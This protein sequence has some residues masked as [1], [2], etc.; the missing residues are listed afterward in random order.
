MT[1]E[2]SAKT[3]KFE[4]EVSQVLSLV[5]NSL[6]SNKDVFLRELIS[7]SADALDKLRFEAIQR[8]ELLPADYQAKIRLIPDEK[9][10][11]L[12]IWDNGIGMSE[13]ALVKDLG[14]VARSGSKELVERLKQADQK[15]DLKLIGQ[16]GVGFYSG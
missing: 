6:Y 14:T 15:H 12:T 7:N 2:A 1:H 13:A 4:A 10:K 9:Q 3:H 11:T 8:P 16:F 5:I